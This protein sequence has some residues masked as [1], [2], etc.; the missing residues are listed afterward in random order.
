MLYS[1]QP[2]LGLGRSLPILIIVTIVMNKIVLF[3]N[4]VYHLLGLPIATAFISVLTWLQWSLLKQICKIGQKF[5]EGVTRVGSGGMCVCRTELY[6]CL[7]NVK[8]AWLIFGLSFETE[9]E[10]ETGGL[11][12][13][14]NQTLWLEN[15]GTFVLMRESHPL[16]V[17]EVF[18]MWVLSSDGNWQWCA[19]WI[20]KALW[21]ENVG[22]CTTMRKMAILASWRS[23]LTVNALFRRKL[24]AIYRMNSNPTVSSWFIDDQ[25]QWVDKKFSVYFTRFSGSPGGQSEKLWQEFFFLVP[26]LWWVLLSGKAI[27]IL[28]IL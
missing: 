26:S 25:G 18:W 6:P 19:G 10:Y 20:P 22:A 9:L 28:L 23:F 8:I 4:W 1:S 15:V 14:L 3:Q 21:L 16:H 2:K 27:A 7:S 17:A 13:L 11:S 24:T 12:S 5:S